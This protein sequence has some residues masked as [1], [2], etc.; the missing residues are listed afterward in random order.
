MGKLQSKLASLQAHI[1]RS[2][3]AEKKSVQE[4]T[5]H[6]ITENAVVKSNALARSYYY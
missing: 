2:A 5:R 6:K 3:K 4:D 1:E